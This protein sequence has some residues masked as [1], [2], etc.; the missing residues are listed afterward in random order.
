MKEACLES[1]LGANP[2][3]VESVLKCEVLADTNQ[4]GK[5]YQVLNR[6]KATII[7]EEI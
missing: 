3:L 5:I 2:R 4:C 7:N 1:F 6:R